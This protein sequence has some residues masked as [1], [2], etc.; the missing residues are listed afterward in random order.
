M[1]GIILAG[2]IGSRLYPLTITTSKQLLPVYDKP[3]IY[4]PLSIL[5]LAKIKDIL[6]ITSPSDLEDFKKLLGNG[7]DLGINICYKI[8]K[9]PKGI[10]ESFLIGEDF[11]KKSNVCLILGDNIFYA[12]NLGS[13]LQKISK[14]KNEAT[15][16]A[17]HVTDPQRFGVVDF[18]KKKII[19]S[20]EEKPSKPKTNF[21]VTG[22]YF[23]DNTVIKKAK[24]LK[25]S[26]RGE[27]EI[28]DLNK[29]YLKEKKLK[30]EFLSRGSACLDTGT[31]ES[32]L[33]A[34]QF[35]QIVENRQGL[36]IACLEEIA[37][38]NKWI[39]KKDI[40][41]KIKSL[42]NSI[43]GNYLSHLVDSKK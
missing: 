11:I 16:F 13:I 14:R 9:K 19:T 40:L 34:S 28:T 41:K 23:Y 21:A 27:L 3:M 29:M 5:M 42:N 26:K 6:I 1:K 15:L 17:Y 24:K 30:V 20:L 25:P 4:Y 22:L 31:H 38:N 8:Q 32:L 36:K 10:A 35:V 2:G 37:Y 7:N 18:D 43:Y 33:E 39:T 12:Q